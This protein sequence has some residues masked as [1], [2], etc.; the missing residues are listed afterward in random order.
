MPFHPSRGLPARQKV[1]HRA[2]RPRRTCCCARER[3]GCPDR[4][5]PKQ[6]EGKHK[7]WMDRRWRPL[8][9]RRSRLKRRPL[10]CARIGYVG[11]CNRESG[12]PSR[13]RINKTA[14]LQKWPCGQP[15]MAVPQGHRL[16]CHYNLFY[17]FVPA[18]RGGGRRSI[19]VGT[20]MERAPFLPTA[21]TAKKWLSV[22]T[23]RRTVSPG[24]AAKS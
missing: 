10:R 11:G 24:D 15:K 1:F 3:P 17:C 21:R 23:P 12:G 8:R 18:G 7:A 14:A 5:D 19:S 20:A 4:S 16:T 9:N 13:L 22:E 2:P 6:H